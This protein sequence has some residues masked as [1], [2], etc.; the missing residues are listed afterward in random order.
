MSTYAK[1]RHFEGAGGG[2]CL[3]PLGYRRRQCPG[4]VQLQ[5]RVGDVKHFAVD[6]VSHLAVQ[7][8]SVAL[9]LATAIMG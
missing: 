6:L 3:G 1:M 7:K 8:T 9:A 4:R 5:V 2:M